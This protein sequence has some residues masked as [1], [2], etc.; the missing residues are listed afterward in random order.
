MIKYLTIYCAYTLGILTLPIA[1]LLLA[2]YTATIIMDNIKKASDMTGEVPYIVL[3][4]S[5]VTYTL[6]DLA[7]L[8][9]IIY[10]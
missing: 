7:L 4:T 9:M 2:I 10:I 1:L 6:L 3:L 8:A 5:I